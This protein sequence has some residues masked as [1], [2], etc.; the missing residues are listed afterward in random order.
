[1]AIINPNG[2]LPVDILSGAGSIDIDAWQYE[3]TSSFNAIIPYLF[4][5]NEQGFAY[6]F[7][8]LTTL[9]QDAAGTIPVTAAGQ[10]VGLMLDK[11]KGLVLGGE[12]NSNN[13]NTNLVGWGVGSAASVI[14]E[15][16]EAKATLGGAITASANNWFKLDGTYVL[17]KRYTVSFDATHVSGGDLQAGFGYAVGFT[18]TAAQNRATKQR[19]TFTSSGI[20]ATGGGLLAFGASTAGS[21]WKIDN[22][23]VREVLGNHAY[24]T[25]AASRPL[26]QRNATTGAYYLAFDGTDDFLVTSSID[27][28][29]TDKISLFAGVRKL[30]DAA[31]G[32]LCEFSADLG[33]NNGAF[34][35]GAPATAG[36]GSITFNSK[37]TSFAAAIAASVFAPVSVVVTGY[38][39]IAAPSS[40][41]RVNGVFKSSNLASQG[42]VKYGNYPLYI[43]RRG[44][45]ALPFNGHLYSLIGIGRLTTDSETTSLEK[46]IAKNVGVTL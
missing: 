30:S 33:S 41:I 35:L 4:R 1:M 23:S 27:F 14:L 7:N 25:N 28:T 22:V 15:N 32:M 37:G 17:G 8:D 24:Q 38:A 34:Y 5:N 2:S 3:K 43:G 11:S 9:Y 46:S 42:S 16:G 31:I 10:P 29:A 6:D 21:V 19:Y 18:V 44:G 39:N 45:T 40:A 12:L 36:N 13:F 26:L 20:F